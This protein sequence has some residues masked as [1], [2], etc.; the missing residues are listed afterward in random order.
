MSRLRKLQNAR[1]I[2]SPNIVQN[3]S[4]LEISTTTCETHTLNIFLSFCLR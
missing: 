4:M 2:V 1:S 3:T